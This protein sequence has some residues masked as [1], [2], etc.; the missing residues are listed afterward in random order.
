MEEQEYFYQLKPLAI[1]G[2]IYLVSFPILTAILWFVINIPAK[3]MTL[4][5]G[6]YLATGLGI[7]A[8]W[9]YGRSKSF[10]VEENQIVLKS[11]V[12]EHVLT[13]GEIRRIALFTTRQG[14]EVVQIKTKKKD[15]YLS[16][17]YFPFPELMI[18]LEHFIKANDIRTNFTCV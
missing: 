13:P 4:L 12:G 2:G 3:E 1:P 8:L 9:I 11:F 10:R 5:L 17:L 7:V 16:E 18:D 14:K 15:F 6:I